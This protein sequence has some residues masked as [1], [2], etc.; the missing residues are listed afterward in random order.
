MKL[1][2]PP[3]TLAVWF[4]HKGEWHHRHDLYVARSRA[5]AI[6][7]REAIPLR[8][9]LVSAAHIRYGDNGKWYKVNVKPVI[10]AVPRE[11]AAWP[12]PPKRPAPTL[13][14][15][16]VKFIRRRT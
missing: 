13:F 2:P 8:G 16:I 9:L 15:K 4:V 6:A 7:W 12:T 5:A 10:C 14:E 11:W 3:G 1:Q